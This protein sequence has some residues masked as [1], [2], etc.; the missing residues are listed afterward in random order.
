MAK[1][2]EFLAPVAAMRG[3]LS[4]NQVL[5]YANGKRAYSVDGSGVVSAENYENRYIGNK[6]NRSG[7]KYFSL[8]RNST[9]NLGAD[10]RF[11]MACFG[12]ACATAAAAKKSLM[13]ISSLQ[14]IFK[15]KK[16]NGEIPSTQSLYNWL[17]TVVY[18]MIQSKQASV[19]VT[20]L[21]HTV[22]IN[23]PWVD[24]GKGTDVQVPEEIVTKFA[25]QL[26]A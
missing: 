4:G 5:E 26:S 13:I 1:I 21:E 19:T 7:K 22:T 9:T 15:A 16:L 18:P 23:N 17:Q 20:D 11:A 10:S 3:N 14:Q 12:G 8:K 25:S 2:I 24:G 6:R